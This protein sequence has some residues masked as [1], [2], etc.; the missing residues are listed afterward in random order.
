MVTTFLQEK[1]RYIFFFTFYLI[2]VHIWG[3]L[4]VQCHTGAYQCYDYMINM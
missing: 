2:K 3:L 4:V 1:F